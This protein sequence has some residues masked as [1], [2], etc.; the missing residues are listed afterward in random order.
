MKKE[1]KREFR[2]ADIQVLPG[3][4]A[5][6]LRSQM[7][8]GTVDVQ[9]LYQLVGRLVHSNISAHFTHNYMA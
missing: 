2:A 9:G 8:V 5:V 3:L 6:R 1:E 4:M 7:Y